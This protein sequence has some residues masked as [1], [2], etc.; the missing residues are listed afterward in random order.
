M[1]NEFEPQA[2]LHESLLALYL[3]E[4]DADALTDILVG[5]LTDAHRILCDALPQPSV[6]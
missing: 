2:G 3:E 1:S 5:A 6:H 4:N